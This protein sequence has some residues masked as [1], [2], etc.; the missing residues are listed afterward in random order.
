MNNRRDIIAYCVLA[1]VSVAVT[2]GMVVNNQHHVPQPKSDLWPKLAACKIDKYYL[3]GMYGIHYTPEM[4]AMEGKQV[5]LDGFVVP[6]EAT[7]KFT[8]FLLS[9]RAPS[10][11]YCPPAAPNEMAEVFSKTP[12]AG[13]EQS[14]SMRGTLKLGDE[15][16]SDGVF[17]QLTDATPATDAPVAEMPAAKP[18]LTKPLAAYQF[19]QLSGKSYQQTR[20]V[21]LAE[22]HGQPLLVLFWRSDCAPCL[23]ELRNL[24]D[25]TARHKSL[26][27]AI[28]S[29]HDLNHTRG[30]LPALPRNAHALLAND[31]ASELLAAFGNDKKLAL[32]YSAMLDSNANL[33]QK[34]NGI[35]TPALGNDWVKQCSNH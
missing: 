17:F 29:L 14:V 26:S 18:V 34:H 20:D 16:N 27:I 25:I 33:C 30:H 12:I 11:P 24:T 15:K 21:S 10:C 8:H 28:I 1:A 2:I 7:E 22:W 6:L 31:D 13:S 5:A 3:E 23:I 9:V 32:P 35:L 4:K 19:T